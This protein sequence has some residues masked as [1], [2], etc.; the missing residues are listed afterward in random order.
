MT[1]C[2]VALGMSLILCSCE[3]AK[4]ATQLVQAPDLAARAQCSTQAATKA[5]AL[6]YPP[7]KASA[8]SHYNAFLEK[9][10]L[11]IDNT[12]VAAAQTTTVIYLLDVTTNRELGEFLRSVRRGESIEDTPALC[13]VVISGQEESCTSPEQFTALARHYME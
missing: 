10:F 2:R 3:D 8:I 9:C 11:R 7:E 4:L 13:N 5:R 1:I 12:S 6:G